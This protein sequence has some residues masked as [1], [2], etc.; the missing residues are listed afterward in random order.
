[1]LAHRRNANQ[2]RKDAE[3]DP[4]VRW[5]PAVDP[6]MAALSIFE[7]DTRY[8]VYQFNMATLNNMKKRDTTL[9]TYQSKENFSTL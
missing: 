5:G 3:K 4:N 8:G 9:S 2:R 7:D 6:G 1:M